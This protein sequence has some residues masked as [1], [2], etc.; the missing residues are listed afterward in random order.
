MNEWCLLDESEIPNELTNSVTS[1]GYGHINTLLHDMIKA[2]N[3]AAAAKL[4]SLKR[5]YYV[6]F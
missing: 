5:F 4:L 3:E 2:G 6:E 1:V